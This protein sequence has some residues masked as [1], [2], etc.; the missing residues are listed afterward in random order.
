[1]N[2]NGRRERMKEPLHWTFLWS[3]EEKPITPLSEGQGHVPAP[4]PAENS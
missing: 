1:M 3:V 2:R 4:L